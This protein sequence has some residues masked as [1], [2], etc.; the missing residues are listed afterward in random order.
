[1]GGLLRGL[2]A[3]WSRIVK[4]L[5]GGVMLRGGGTLI[6]GVIEWTLLSRGGGRP[7]AGGAALPPLSQAG[8]CHPVPVPSLTSITCKAHGCSRLNGAY[9]VEFM[10]LSAYG[11]PRAVKGRRAATLWMG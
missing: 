11:L 1:M 9:P 2:P 10:Q 8:D 6:V 3:G 4:G 7:I 5:G